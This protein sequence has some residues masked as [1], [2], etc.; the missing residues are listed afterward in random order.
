[1]TETLPARAVTVFCGSRFGHDPG[2]RAD[3]VALGRG[4]AQAGLRLVYG[5]G[6]VGLMGALA[7]AVLLAGGAVTGIIPE[8][9]TRLEVAHDRLTELVVTESMHSRKSLMFDR[10]DAFVTMPG[11]LGT[12]DETV[13]IIT[14]RQLGLHDKPV[15]ICNTGGWANALL[16]A[17]D[18]T[19]TGGFAGPGTRDFYQ[20]VPSVAALLPL[21]VALPARQGAHTAKL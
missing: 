4:I 16:A 18:A 2:L 1:L 3:M 15:F 19:V 20:V 11:G 7:D 13:E 14:W 6:R 5:G 10:A 12:L 17:F 8:F 9:L 21:L